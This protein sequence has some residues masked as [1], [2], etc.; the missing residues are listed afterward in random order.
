MEDMVRWF[1]LVLLVASALCALGR[2]GMA[3]VDLFRV[4]RE[5]R[6]GGKAVE[7]RRW[8]LAR[9][10]LSAAAALLVLVGAHLAGVPLSG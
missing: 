4:I 3:N 9:V 2:F 1:G 8:R 5:A 6:G 10:V 7:T